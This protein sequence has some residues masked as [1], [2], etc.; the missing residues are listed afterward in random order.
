MLLTGQCRLSLTA[1]QPVQINRCARGVTVCGYRVLPGAL[2]L[3]QRRR[4][5]YLA[6]VRAAEAAYLGGRLDALGLQRASDAA[7]AI[8]AHADAAPWRRARRAARPG[9]ACED[10]V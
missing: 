1:K 3:S 6:A 8:T 2:R 9:M 10:L 4:R 7:L 5:R